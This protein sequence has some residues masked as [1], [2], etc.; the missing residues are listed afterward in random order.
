MCLQPGLATQK[1]EN[2]CFSWPY[3]TEHYWDISEERKD[4]CDKLLECNVDEDE[5]KDARTSFCRPYFLSWGLFSGRGSEH[6]SF[7]KNK[8]NIWFLKPL[9]SGTIAK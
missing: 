5:I 8:K 9:V 6:A 3:E 2:L 7:Y 1:V 4:V